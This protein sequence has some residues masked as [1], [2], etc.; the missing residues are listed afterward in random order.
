[1]ITCH[2]KAFTNFL[3]MELLLD[4]P[5][6]KY[7]FLKF[8]Q[9]GFK[10]T[11]FVIKRAIAS[12]KPY[13]FSLLATLVPK[14]DLQA[15]AESAVYELFGPYLD[16]Y[17]SLNVPWDSQAICRIIHTFD[18]SDEV[19][20]RALLD[21]PDNTCTFDKVHPNFPVTRPYLKARPY[22]LWRWILDSYGPHHRYSIACFDDAL[23]RASADS[24][25]HH[26]IEHYLASGVVMRPRHIKIIACR[27][28]HRNMTA[29]ALK[30]MV[31]LRRQVSLRKRQTK[32]TDPEDEVCQINDAE[33]LD[34]AKAI[35]KDVLLNEDWK[36]KSSTIQLGGGA[37]GG[38]LEI[39]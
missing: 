29:N 39:N 17:T 12:G 14:S 36:T 38:I 21:K 33:L 9:H 35:K 23:S 16:R 5:V 1:M 22:A 10:L 11:D 37:N 15:L 27:I 28:L 20:E 31:H 6:S 19:I 7:I 25:L 30:V 18:I 2:K 8:L 13:C 26:L 34:F 3:V 4:K 24:S 32:G